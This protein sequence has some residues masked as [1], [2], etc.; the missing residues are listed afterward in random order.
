MNV[1]DAEGFSA[2][3]EVRERPVDYLDFT[4]DGRESQQKLLVVSQRTRMPNSAGRGQT[5]KPCV[6]Q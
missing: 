1:S 5:E 6:L 4:R 2:V 3:T